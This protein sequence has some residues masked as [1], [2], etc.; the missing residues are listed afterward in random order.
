MIKFKSPYVVIL[1]GPP[2]SGKTTFIKNKMESNIT[3]ISRDQIVLD[4]S[5]S[6]DYNHSFSTVNQKDVDRV[7]ISKIKNASF[8]KENVVIDMTNMTKKRRKYNL[9]FFDDDYYKVAILFPI[10][11]D[12]E[13]ESRNAKRSKEEKKNIPMNIIKNMIS[14]YQPISEDEG[15]DKILISSNI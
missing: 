13:F 9:S 15:F 2:L 11:S 8:L 5:E 3:T 6:D 12:S 7:L 4:L 10:I 14:S 1:V